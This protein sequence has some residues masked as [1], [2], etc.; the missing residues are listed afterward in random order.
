MILLLKKD[1][2]LTTH[3]KEMCWNWR[4]S[5]LPIT[6][7]IQNRWG[8]SKKEKYNTYD[9]SR[10]YFGSYSMDGLAM[11]LHA[12]YHSKD[13]LDAISRAVNLLGDADS[14]G[15]IAGQIAGAFYGYQGIQNVAQALIED[16]D[17]WCDGDIAYR[18]AVLFH[19]AKGGPRL[20][21]S[22]GRIAPPPVKQSW[23]AK[24][25]E[26]WK[27][28]ALITT[29]IAAVGGILWW[30]QP[31]TTTEENSGGS[32]LISDRFISDPKVWG[33]ALG[34]G[35]LGTAALAWY[36]EW[37]PF[38]ACA[39]PKPES[40]SSEPT[41]NRRY[42]AVNKSKKKSGSGNIVVIVVIVAVVLIAVGIGLYFY[43]RNTGSDFYP[44]M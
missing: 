14:T 31:D 43:C 2:L 12:C 17:K 10:P 27:T 23:L 11:A 16:M 33:G 34:L 40:A 8:E 26:E 15:S 29:A 9:V 42:R 21:P 4:K 41:G 36:N 19:V 7:T 22:T 25:W 13:F 1:D 30:S 20:D 18:A 32:S 6:A 39:N 38:Q 35:A 3:P 28:P 5:V 24:K 44:E 37:N